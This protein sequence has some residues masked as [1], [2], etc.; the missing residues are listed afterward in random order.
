[1]E[2]ILEVK[3]LKK[4]FGEFTALGGVSF[5]LY[6]GET[7]GLVGESGS[8]KSTIAN[9]IVGIH[10][11]SS[12]GVIFKK[13]ELWKNNK[14]NCNEYG[15]IQIVFQ[16]P[17]SSL[18]P[19]MTIKSIVSEPLLAFPKEIRREKGSRENLVKLI[20]SV[21]LQEQHLD[22]YPH[23]FSGGQRQ[24]IA[25]ARAIITEPEILILDEPTSALDVSVQAQILNLL[26]DIQ[27]EK[28]M[29][30]LFISHNMAVV[31]YISSRVGVLYKGEFVEMGNSKQI[32]DCPE[33]DY[34]K[35]LI[36]SILG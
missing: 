20:K 27:R 12:G 22:R 15:K 34:T 16:D 9:I 3:E 13:K 30:Y 25:I 21:G 26:K 2:S 14:Y 24:R 5:E 18:D 35:K 32:F 4:V 1:M 8:G 36:S 29:T 6:K 10:S 19:R 33:H 7:F 17:R 31:K 11:P 23:E 28:H